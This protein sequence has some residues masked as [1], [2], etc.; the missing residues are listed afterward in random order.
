MQASDFAAELAWSAGCLGILLP[1]TL[2]IALDGTLL[3]CLTVR[4]EESTQVLS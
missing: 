1:S 4:S 3:A 2:P